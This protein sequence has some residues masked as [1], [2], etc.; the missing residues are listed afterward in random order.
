MCSCFCDRRKAS[1]RV[2]HKASFEAHTLQLCALPPALRPAATMSVQWSNVQKSAVPLRAFSQTRH[3][4][5]Q[6]RTPQCSRCLAPHPRGLVER[7]AAALPTLTSPL[8]LPEPPEKASLQSVLPYLLKLSWTEPRMPLRFSL[9][10]V[11]LCV[12]KVTGAHL[13]PR[14]DH[15]ISRDAETLRAVHLPVM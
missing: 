5:V 7:Q 6:Q 1:C 10:L 15:Q 13:C 3:A 14:C 9:A 8:P 2:S 11:A 4:R 12:S